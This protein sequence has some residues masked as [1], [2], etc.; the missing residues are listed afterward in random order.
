M[1]SSLRSKVIVSDWVYAKCGF[2]S[3]R[4]ILFAVFTCLL[5]IGT[6]NAETPAVPEGKPALIISGN[7][8][9]PNVGDEIHVDIDWIKSLPSVSFDS[10]TPWAEGKQSFVGVRLSVFFDSLGVKPKYFTAIGLDGYKADVKVN[11]NKYPALIAYKH[12]GKDISV[13]RLGPLR[14][15]YPFDDYPELLTDA[16]VASAVWQLT[17]IELF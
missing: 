11:W 16:N 3:S 17:K 14:V 2:A 10:N 9:N 7:V 13:R 6:A 1:D 15:I 5:S 12:N 4:H 8:T